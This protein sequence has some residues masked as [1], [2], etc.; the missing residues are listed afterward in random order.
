MTPTTSPPRTLPLAPRRHRTAAITLDAQS[1]SSWDT[2]A[3]AWRVVPGCDTI[4]VGSS[5]RSLP[6]HA[7]VAQGGARCR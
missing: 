7:R 1:F 6:L 3:Q 4:R 5:S 2:T